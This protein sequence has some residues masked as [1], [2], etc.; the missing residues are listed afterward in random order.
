LVPSVN[1]VVEDGAGRAIDPGESLSQAS[2]RPSNGRRIDHYLELPS[3]P[4]FD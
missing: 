1:V 3:A 2:E 4:H